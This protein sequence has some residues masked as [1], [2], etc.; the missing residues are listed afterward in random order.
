[1]AQEF[2]YPTRV[3]Y[4]EVDQQLRL[5]LRGA[6]AMMQEAAIVHS[7]QAGYA[8]ADIPRTHVIW[9]LVRWRVKRIGAVRWNE[10]VT[11]ET[12]PRSMARVTSVR[13]FILR[14]ADGAPAAVGESE[15]ILVNT[16]TG[17]AARITPEIAGAYSLLERDV[18]DQ[19]FPTLS[20]TPGPV[21]CTLETRRSDIDT[22]H[23]V[24]NLVYL[25]Y[26]LEALPQDCWST[27]FDEISMEFRR[28]IL[29]GQRIHCC[30]RREQGIY[31]V[32][33]VGEDGCLHGTVAFRG[34]VS[35]PVEV[36]DSGP[37]PVL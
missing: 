32:D 35:E 30:Y 5:T 23:H 33:L 16:D 19:P 28:Q 4:G 2:Q 14:G 3:T 17:R 34:P 6:M 15:W 9:M 37:E 25:D 12:W 26:A 27:P 22:N 1:M 31:V 18:F 24:N 13:N 36:L 10:A 7:S 11:V 20:H 29:L 21:V 8:V